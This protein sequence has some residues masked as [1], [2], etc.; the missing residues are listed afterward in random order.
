SALSASHCNKSGVSASCATL[1]LL[2]QSSVCCIDRLNP[3]C[4]AAGDSAKAFDADR[5]SLEHKVDDMAASLTVLD[6]ES[7]PLYLSRRPI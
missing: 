5:S 2:A 1:L 6:D 3:P 7:G 4:Q